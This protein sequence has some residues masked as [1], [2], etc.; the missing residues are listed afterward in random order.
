MENNPHGGHRERLKNR[1]L[2]SGLKDFE[3]HNVLE[4]LL[5]FAIP[6]RD[7]NPLA[8][9]LISEFGSLDAV[10]DASFE[11]LVAVSGVGANTATLIKLIPELFKKYT[12]KK[13]NSGSVVFKTDKFYELMI[14]N[15]SSESGESVWLY[16]LDNSKVLIDSVMLYRG[17]VNS[18]SFDYR[19]IVETS[20]KKKASYIV[21]MHNHPGGIA[22]P[23]T[24]DI[25]TTKTVFQIMGSIGLNL[26]EHYVVAGSKTAGIL[27]S[28]DKFSANVLEM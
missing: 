15:A 24:T 1:F 27:H 22:F 17:S 28:D 6:Q 4:L 8:H 20:L 3:D 16:M 2:A 26:L 7:V 10:F 18:V 12:D 11:D 5:F 13:L 25:E 14:A 21:L 23:S 19:K 9:K